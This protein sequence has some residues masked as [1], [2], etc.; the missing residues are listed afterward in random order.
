MT[1]TCDRRWT[2]PRCSGCGAARPR[3]S[4]RRC[5]AGPGEQVRLREIP[6]LTQV[7]LRVTP[8]SVGRP[9][10]GARRDLPPGS[11]RSPGPATAAT[12]RSCGS[13]PTSSSRSDPTRPTPGS[14]RRRMPV[15]WPTRWAPSRGRWSTCRPTAP[16]SSCRGRA[17]VPC[18]RRAATSTCTHACS[19]S[20]RRRD[21][22]GLHGGHPVAHGRGHLARD[23]AGVLRD[24][25]GA[26]AARRDAGVRL[27][28]LS[29]L[30][31]FSVGIGPSSSHTVGPMRAARRF[32]AGLAAT[33][34]S[35][36]R[37]GCRRSSTVRSARPATATART[38]PSCSASRART[39]RPST[40]RTRW[41]GSTRSARD[42][43]IALD[44]TH[45]VDFD[46][47]VDL[48]LHRRRTLPGHPN[49]M[50][51]E[52]F[53][54]DGR[55]LRCATFY[56]VGGGFVVDEEAVGADRVVV[57][58]TPVPHPFG[59]GAELLGAAA[60]PGCRSPGS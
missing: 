52:A 58:T 23:A 11:A 22:A 27:M 16:R 17:P 1:T 10:R 24:P 14:P 9:R 30:D 2:E 48:V 35:T 7:A 25:R 19:R 20:A 41:P 18:S 12:S 59:T 60:R 44:G 46:P 50:T 56:S 43:K 42:R 49:G 26:L 53:D 36:G 39:Q 31:L 51:F 54:E 37:R 13:R 33:A 45:R 29:A 28:S 21:P 55:S 3:T 57:D 47:D 32:A 40:P 8:G 4:P 6:F 38:G 15:G 5:C 34:C